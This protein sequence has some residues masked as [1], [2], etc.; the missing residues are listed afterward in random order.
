MNDIFFKRVGLDDAKKELRKVY[1]ANMKIG[2]VMNGL[3][4][5]ILAIDGLSKAESENI[6]D[7]WMKYNLELFSVYGDAM[8]KQN[9]EEIRIIDKERRSFQRVKKYL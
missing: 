3:Y 9:W 7:Y 4:S 6:R 5:M 8:L 2:R 1:I